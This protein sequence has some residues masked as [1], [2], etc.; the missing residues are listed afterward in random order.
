MA[1]CWN[2]I[3][4]SQTKPLVWIKELSLSSLNTHL[5]THLTITFHRNQAAGWSPIKPSMR[6]KHTAQSSWRSNITFSV[7][8]ILQTLYR[9]RARGSNYS[10]FH[11]VVQ[12]LLQKRKKFRRTWKWGKKKSRRKNNWINQQIYEAHSKFML[13]AI[14]TNYSTHQIH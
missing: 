11:Y 4:S 13:V 2:W 3:F 7:L 10:R 5:C 6:S 1:W 14:I 8:S 12:A 9:Y